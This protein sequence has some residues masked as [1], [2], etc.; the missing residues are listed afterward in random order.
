MSGQYTIIGVDFQI[1]VLTYH[2]ISEYLNAKSNE[3]YEN[4]DFYLEGNRDENGIECDFSYGKNVAEVKS[5]KEFT[6][7]YGNTDFL[8]TVHNFIK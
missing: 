6:V 1:E 8:K 7:G 5:S 3:N 4:I 2:I